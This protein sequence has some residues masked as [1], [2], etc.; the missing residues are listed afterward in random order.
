L[1]EL[2]KILDAAEVLFR[3]YGVRSVTMS[4]IAGQIGISK[5][6]LYQH[7]ENKHDLI[8]KIM[9]KYINEEIDMCCNIA[10]TAADAL[11]EMLKIS[12]QVQRN[13]ENMNPSLLFDLRKYH[14]PIWQHFENHRKEFILALIEN[15]LER[16]KKEGIYRAELNSGI[17]GRI[18]IGT[19][20]I[21]AD[22]ELL[23]PDAFPRPLVHREFVLYH[24]HGIVSDLGRS[25]LERYLK[26]AETN[27]N[28]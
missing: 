23:P 13:I 21:F 10:E 1:D 7:I 25:L 14:F 4:D 28:L 18:Q 15:N 22:D 12:L 8:E 3:K 16:G 27:I 20:E 9:G 17:V 2:Q 26:Q 19:I 5:K 6:T 11:D 24:L